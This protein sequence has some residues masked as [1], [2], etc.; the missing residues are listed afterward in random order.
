M[1]VEEEKE[2]CYGRY[3]VCRVSGKD[4]DIGNLYKWLFNNY[5]GYKFAVMI[6]C[7]KDEYED[8]EESEPVYFLDT[9]VEE[10]ID[11][12]GI[13]TVQK[14]IDEMKKARGL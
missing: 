13:D 1:I 5:Q 6:D 2:D 4:K 14:K 10:V 11:Y 12:C 7:T 9:V 3:P 8:P